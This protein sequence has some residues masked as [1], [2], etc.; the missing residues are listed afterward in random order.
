MYATITVCSNTKK[1]IKN[2]SVECV[3]NAVKHE[4]K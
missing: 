1:V 4:L 3:W 2:L